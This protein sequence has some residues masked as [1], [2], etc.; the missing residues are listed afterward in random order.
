M[1]TYRLAGGQRQV[2][3]MDHYQRVLSD[4]AEEYA[5]PRIARPE[6]VVRVDVDWTKAVQHTVWYVGGDA[7]SRP[8]YRYRR[9]R[10]VLSELAPGEG[11]KAHVDLGCG[12]GL[13]LWVFLD[14]AT[15]HGIE[16]DRLGLYGMDHSPSMIKLAKK[17]K[18]RLSKHEP[19]YPTLH[20]SS[21]VNDLCGRLT[22]NHRDGTDYNVTLGH[23]LVQAHS[24]GTIRSFTQVV[25][26]IMELKNPE[27]DCVLI[28]MDADGERAAFADG[29]TALLDS[30]KD[31]GIHHEENRNSTSAINDSG[32]AKLAW[33]TPGH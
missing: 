33:L 26:H 9:Y 4:I 18:T 14:W 28:A 11:R 23:V 3:L 13:F 22:D 20:Y 12:A 6:H 16:R 21:D 7:D 29:W 10:E 17:I 1:D 5:I 2:R 32:R 27:D 30:L 8:H 24:P 19:D 25:S 31:A 15:D